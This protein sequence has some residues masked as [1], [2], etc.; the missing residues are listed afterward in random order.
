MPFNNQWKEGFTS[1]RHPGKPGVHPVFGFSWRLPLALCVI[2]LLQ[3]S[4]SGPACGDDD[5]STLAIL[6][7]KADKVS[8]ETAAGVSDTLTK[9]LS[10]S[11]K[12]R[13][14]SRTKV[15]EVTANTVQGYHEFWI[16]DQA[17]CA[18]L[19]GRELPANAVIIG[20][21]TRFGRLITIEAEAVDMNSGQIAGTWV[22]ESFTG[23][24]GIP[25]AVSDLAGK[26]IS[27]RG[28]FPRGEVRYTPREPVQEEDLL[29]EDFQM[30]FS[31]GGGLGLSGQESSRF[32]CS[33]ADP[34]PTDTATVCW[35]NTAE[36]RWVAELGLLARMR[37]SRLML[38]LRSGAASAKTTWLT[39]YETA[40]YSDSFEGEDTGFKFYLYPHL[41]FVLYE[42]GN[43]R[44]MVSGGVGYRD[45]SDESLVSKSFAASGLSLRILLVRIDLTYWHGLKAK[46]LL[47]DMV[48]LNLGAGIGF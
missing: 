8:R 47:Q 21:V 4:F 16:C 32:V 3:G 45:F 14:W 17:D 42:T 36:I 48:T 28:R 18:V 43:L 44:A 24:E 15:A 1:M 25:A 7:F 34:S 2:L 20:S 46:T 22:T 23:E 13:L 9:R 41:G 10:E 19:V 30:S 37:E 26:I 12:F 33:I 39:T 31:L 38:G 40:Y 27:D 5:L 35:E 29:F 6:D 11:G